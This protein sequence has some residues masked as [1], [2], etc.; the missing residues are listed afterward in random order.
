[1]KRWLP[2]WTIPVLIVMAIGTVWL[3]LSIVG[4]TYSI[5]QADRKIRELQQEREQLELKVTGLRSPR[6]LELLA[7]TRFGLSQPRS[8]QLIHMPQDA[9]TR[10]EPAPKAAT[11]RTAKPTASKTLVKFPA[12]SARGGRNE[13]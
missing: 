6:R 4:T 11:R 1:M 5:A 10:A 9:A 12:K 2:I 7:K 3:R 13:R 8:E